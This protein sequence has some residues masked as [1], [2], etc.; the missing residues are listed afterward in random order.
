MALDCP[1]SLFQ[2]AFALCTLSET[3]T[4]PKAPVLQGISVYNTSTKAQVSSPAY[5]L[6]AG[7]C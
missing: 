6:A 7:A 5:Y 3:L 2:V 1:K 4:I